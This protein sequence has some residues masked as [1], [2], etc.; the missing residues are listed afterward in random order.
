M[1]IPGHWTKD[2]NDPPVRA[3]TLLALCLRWAQMV[4]WLE[5]Q[6]TH[7]LSLR[8]L[9]AQTNEYDEDPDFMTLLSWVS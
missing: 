6:K 3:A 7:S 2:S 9:Q 5:L 1:L 4:L 8:V